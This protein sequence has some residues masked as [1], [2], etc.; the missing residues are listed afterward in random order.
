MPAEISWYHENRIIYERFY[1]TITVEEMITLTQ[2]SEEYREAGIPLVH[3]IV[4]LSGIESFPKNLGAIRAAIKRPAH[5]E[6]I[7]WIII[8]GTQNPILKF[9][10]SAITQ[11]FGG[12]VRFRLCETLEQ[13][14]AFLTERDQTLPELL[15]PSQ[16]ETETNPADS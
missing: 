10:A 16:S 13:S 2:K 5:M 11:V 15:P 8:Y 4:D 14:L 9:F 12:Q 6:R 1:G 3:T 7:G